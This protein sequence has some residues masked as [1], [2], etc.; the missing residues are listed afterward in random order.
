[1]AVTKTMWHGELREMGQV[2]VE[3]KKEAQ[4]SK[5]GADKPDYVELIVGGHLRQYMVEAP[6]CGEFFRGRVGQ[7]ILIEAHESREAATINLIGP[8][9][10]QTQQRTD[11]P[12][13][14]APTTNQP[15]ASTRQAAAPTNQP[16]NPAPP[17]SAPAP[18]KTREE[19]EAEHLAKNQDAVNTARKF[20]NKKVNAFE[21]A[22]LAVDHLAERRAKS[23]RAITPEQF[24]GIV[25]SIFISMDRA[26][27]SDTLPTGDLDKYLPEPKAKQ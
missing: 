9:K 23:G 15:P 4:K 24:Q 17:A 25:T 21:I 19:L 26:G 27:L 3:V 22:F 13:R 7:K 2:E 8:P 1:M 18:K 20:A 11:V 16:N 5:Y 10:G 14:S 6:Q 12:P